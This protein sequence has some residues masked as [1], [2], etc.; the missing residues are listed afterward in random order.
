MVMKKR[1]K[2]QFYIIGTVAIVLIIYGL[3][4]LMQVT[5]RFDL[6][7]PIASTG[8]LL[9]YK[10]TEDMEFLNQTYSAEELDFIVPWY[11]N[12][13]S[14][15]AVVSDVKLAWFYNSSSTPRYVVYEIISS[16]FYLKKRIFFG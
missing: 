9:N 5:V 15:K 1:A 16:D 4:S 11:F 8:M 6:S 14:E 13:L 10:I 3:L 12:S 7:Q 2:A